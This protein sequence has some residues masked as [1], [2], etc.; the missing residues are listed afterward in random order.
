M[1]YDVP[2]LLLCVCVSLFFLGAEKMLR[3]SLP[4][5]YFF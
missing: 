2:K 5:K 3:L 1:I 4:R